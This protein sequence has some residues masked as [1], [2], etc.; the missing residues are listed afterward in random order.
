MYNAS[1]CNGIITS[2]WMCER[3]LCCGVL[4]WLWCGM[5]GSVMCQGVGKMS[6]DV[7]MVICKIIAA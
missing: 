4:K 7:G 6:R 3:I 5:Q 1:Y 2:R